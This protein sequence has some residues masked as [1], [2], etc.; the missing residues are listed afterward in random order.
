LLNT[1]VA[2]SAREGGVDCG[3]RV[4]TGMGGAPPLYHFCKDVIRWGLRAGA[5]KDM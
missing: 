1:P 4:G 2:K 3:R 5:A